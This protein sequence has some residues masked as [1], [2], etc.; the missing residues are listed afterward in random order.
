[1]KRIVAEKKDKKGTAIHV[2]DAHCGMPIGFT[3]GIISA[4]GF[5]L[6][7]YPDVYSA[8]A[9]DAVTKGNGWN[10]FDNRVLTGTIKKMMESRFELFVFDSDKAL[11]NWVAKGGDS[12][13]IN[14]AWSQSHFLVTNDKAEMNKSIAAADVTPYMHLGAVIQGCRAFFTRERYGE[15]S[16][17]PYSGVG[18]RK[19]LFFNAS[20]KKPTLVE[21]VQAVLRGGNE[22]HAFRTPRDLFFWVAK[23]S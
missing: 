5:I 18:L 15:G 10:A 2:D 17:Y 19:G 11:L 16:Y 4:R 21:S 13:S 20:Y 14:V 22:V 12:V 3:P 8:R 9:A 1:M 7:P 23:G 6:R